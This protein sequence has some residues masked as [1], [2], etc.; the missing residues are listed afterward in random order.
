MTRID[1]IS[2]ALHRQAGQHGPVILMYHAVLPGQTVPAWPWAVSMQQFRDQLDFLAAEGYQTPT[3][4][5]LAAAPAKTWQG[6]TAVIT[7]DDV[8]ADNL[9]ACEELKRRGMRATWFIV[10]GSV[11]QPP[12]RPE[13]GRPAGRLLIADELREMQANGMDIGPH[14]VNH[15]RLSGLVDV[16]LMQELTHSK[17]ILEDMLGNPVGSFAYPYG[18]WD[19]RCVQAAQQAGYAAAG[20]AGAGGAGRGRAPY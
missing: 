6:R 12:R 15:V 4:A 17:A 10:A 7:V 16:S 20:A 1:P 5:E 2:R 11:G 18:D 14:T 19:A 13:D 3:M 9:A 8:Y